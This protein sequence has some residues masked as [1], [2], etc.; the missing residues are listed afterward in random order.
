MKKK[1]CILA[2]YCYTDIEDP[3]LEV[4]R[5][6]KF[7]KELDAK[8]RIYIAYNGIN[9]QMSLRQEDAYSYIDWLK[10]DP[11]FANTMFKMDPSDEHVFPRLTIKFRKQLVS[12]DKLPDIAKGGEHVPPEKWKKMLEERDE[13][14]ILIDVRNGYESN[15]GHFD[16]AECPPLEAFREFPQYAEELAHRKD[17]KNTKVMMY[18]TGGIRCET[19]SALLK[20]LGFNEV[21]QLL[22][23]VI[24]Y[25]HEVGNEHWKGKLFV[26]DDRLSA[27]LSDEKHELISNC[28]FCNKKCDTYY[29][30]ANM[31]CNELFL[32][33]PDC[34]EKYRGCCCEECSK[35]KRRRPYEKTE[36]PKPFRKW[37]HY[38][39]TKEKIQNDDDTS[40]N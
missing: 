34:A 2:F 38:S 26:F 12:L 15:I 30:C 29:N 36:R 4:K 5:H 17:P 19:Y 11:R 35:T 10:S 20:E 6:R 31:D 23:G 3:H 22:G 24:H 40:G 32:C 33:C 39:E 1:Y 18:C 13:N 14:T 8:A 28:H 25:G 27:P 21:Y 37:Y 7:L 16:G 9:A